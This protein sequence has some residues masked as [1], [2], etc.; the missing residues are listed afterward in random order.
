MPGWAHAE[1]GE[2][3]TSGHRIAVGSH[4]GCRPHPIEIYTIYP[5]CVIECDGHPQDS[6]HQKSKHKGESN[7]VKDRR[8]CPHCGKE[9]EKYRN[10]FPTVDII[11]EIDDGIV[12]IRRKNPPYGWAIPGGFV[13]IGETVP[14]AAARE[15]W[16]E[17]QLHVEI[18][19]LVG[20]YSYPDTPVIVIVYE[21]NV[22]DGVLS[23]ADEAL[24]VDLASPSNIPWDKL[25]FTSTRQALRDYL[26]KHY[27]EV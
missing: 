14:E 25:A 22:K 4:S 15:A 1:T 17:V 5:G 13:D 12:L 18:G 19:P 24:E 27:P 20:V 10:P 6:L 23:A 26:Q 16:E 7:P 3:D 21:A 9:V 11:I 8:L 2:G